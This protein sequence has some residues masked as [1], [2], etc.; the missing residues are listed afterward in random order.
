MIY[1]RAQKTKNKLRSIFEIKDMEKLKYILR[2]WFDKDLETSDIFLSQYFYF[3]QIL[4]WFGFQSLNSE[5]TPFSAKFVLTKFQF[6]SNKSDL[7]YI[8][9]KPYCKAL[10]LLMWVQAVT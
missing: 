4:E 8:K 7:H 5:S 6:P 1:K 3:K 2:V 9:D 10:G